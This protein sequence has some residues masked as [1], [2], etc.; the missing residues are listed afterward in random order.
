VK[1]ASAL[2]CSVELSPRTGRRPRRRLLEA[3]VRR[4]QQLDPNFRM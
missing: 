3:R 1:L 2:N 4:S